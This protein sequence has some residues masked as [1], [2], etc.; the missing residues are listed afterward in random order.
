M[1]S[2]RRP[3]EDNTNTN[4]VDDNVKRLLKDGIRGKIP[5]STIAELRR[6]YKDDNLIDK[7]EEVFYERLN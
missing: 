7:I 5:S 2:N 1:S 3:E 4:A 6:R